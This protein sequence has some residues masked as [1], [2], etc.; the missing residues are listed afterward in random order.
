MN[1]Q[2][3]H[4]MTP[5]K[6]FTPASSEQEIYEHVARHLLTQGARSGPLP[7]DRGLGYK[8]YE[9]TCQLKNKDGKQC[10]IGCLI[11]KKSYYR[12]LEGKSIESLDVQQATGVFRFTKCWEVKHEYRRRLSMLRSLQ[13]LHDIGYH[14]FITYSVDHSLPAW[15][16]E[17]AMRKALV[18]VAIE[19]NLDVLFMS[20]ISDNPNWESSMR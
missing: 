20:S 9:D 7:S 15:K 19:H 5:E 12:G 17:N 8:P 14:R 10:A 13:L 11:P 4:K 16:S 6:V 3:M 2:V 18:L 1:I